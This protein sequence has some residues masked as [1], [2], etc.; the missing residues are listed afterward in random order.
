MT[1][2]EKLKELRKSFGLSQ[3]QLADMMNVSRQA[4][5][6]WETDRGLPDVTNLQEI[7]QLFGISIDDL[8]NHHIEYPT[9]VMRKKL[10][11]S[12]YK[13]LLSSYGDILK[14]YYPE[15]WKVYSL[16]RIAK[17]NTL[18]QVLNLL[19]GGILYSTIKDLSDLSPYY[20]AIK[21]QTKL[22]V[23][24]KKWTLEV[25]Q[26]PT[27]INLKK[28]TIGDSQFTKITQIDLKSI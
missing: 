19:S 4:I 21:D 7:S 26:L 11:K 25:Y 16:V 13:N 10:D 1:F 27:D 18:E 3:E 12:Q 24:I 22:L 23:N 20:L 9:L 6:K 15:P 5:T 17:L 2:G 14:E 8:L 28:F